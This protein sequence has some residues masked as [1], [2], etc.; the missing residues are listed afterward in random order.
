MAKP[1]ISIHDIPQ[2]TVKWIDCRSSLQD[3]AEG[4]RQYDQGH[5]KGAVYWDLEQDLSDMSS[6]EGRHPMPSKMQLKELFERSGVQQDDVIILY[7]NGG[8]PFAPRGWYMLEYAN[9]KKAYILREGWSRLKDSDVPLDSTVP[10][11]ERTNLDIAWNE[12]IRMTKESV[13]ELI[14]KKIAG[15][16]LDARSEE[17]Y[18]G[19]HEPIDPVAGHIPGALNYNWER[20]KVSGQFKENAED[21]SDTVSPSNTITVYCGSGVTAA[22]LYAM[23]KHSG[24]PDV[25]L[26]V[27]S[28]SDWVRT[29]AVEKGRPN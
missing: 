22:P 23:L 7:D 26:Y 5:V 3:A 12:E 1:F 2:G 16:L 27:G 15:I 8:E 11:P 21:L 13:K 24:Y 10:A 25:K 19:E 14:S 9:F 6:D 29:E 28:Y 17:R 4:R 20:L 18:L